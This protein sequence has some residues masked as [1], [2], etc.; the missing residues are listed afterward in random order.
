M[1]ERGRALAMMPIC[2][3]FE[4]RTV[5]IVGPPPPPAPPPSNAITPEVGAVLGVG[6]WQVDTGMSLPI[7]PAPFVELEAGGRWRALSLDAFG[8]YTPVAASFDYFDRAATPPSHYVARD[9]MFDGGLKGRVD[10]G[11]LALGGGFG[12]EPQHELGVSA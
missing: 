9:T 5:E 8:V 7:A 1:I 2:R 6:T 10:V 12:I 3:R 11:V 4:D